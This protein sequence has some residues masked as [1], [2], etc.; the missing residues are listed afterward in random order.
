VDARVTVV[1]KGQHEKQE[2]FYVRMNNAT[3]SLAAEEKAKYIA[4]RTWGAGVNPGSI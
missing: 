1:K 3:R 2:H 4:A